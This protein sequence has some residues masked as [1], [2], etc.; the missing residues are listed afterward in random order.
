MDHGEKGLQPIRTAPPATLGQHGLPDPSS[1]S[2]SEV[3]ISP[4][5]SGSGRASVTLLDSWPVGL[6][7][8]FSKMFFND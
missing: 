7:G 5:G 1:S 3:G 2:H 4:G 6:Q 8:I